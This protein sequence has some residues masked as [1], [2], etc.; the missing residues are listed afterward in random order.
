MPSSLRRRDEV[1]DSV[2]S[3]WIRF[4]MRGDGESFALV[5]DRTAPALL[6][7]ARRIARQRNDADD[8]IQA[9]FVTAI[10]RALDFDPTRA[11]LPWLIGILAGHAKNAARAARRAP[12]VYGLARSPNGPN[13]SNSSD[14]TQLASLI[15]LEERAAVALAIDELPRPYR[16]ILEAR[17]DASTS[18]PR[19]TGITPVHLRVGFHRA[20]RLLRRLLPQSLFGVIPRLIDARHDRHTIDGVRRIL[21]TRFEPGARIVA[22]TSVTMVGGI[23]MGKKIAAMAACVLLIVAGAWVLRGDRPDSLSEARDRRTSPA[24]TDQNASEPIATTAEAT[25]IE[26]N[27]IE[28]SPSAVASEPPV[29]FRGRIIDA[30]SG[31]PVAAATVFVDSTHRFPNSALPKDAVLTQPDGRFLI[32]RPRFDGH[33]TLYARS[34]DHAEARREFDVAEESAARRDGVD[35]GDLSIGSGATLH[36]RVLDAEGR[37]VEGARLFLHDE[38][39]MQWAF[40]PTISREVGVTESDG[41][42]VIEHVREGGLYR[43]RLFAESPRGCGGCDL[44]IPVG[45]AHVEGL[46]IRLFRAA[47]L[48]V[49][50]VDDSGAPL[51]GTFVSAGP[52]EPPFVWRS[53]TDRPTMLW[54]CET[55]SEFCKATDAAGRVRF[56]ALPLEMECALSAGREGHLRATASA[57]RL[58][59]TQ[60]TN[61][62]LVMPRLRE[63]A[64]SGRVVDSAGRG[65][66]GVRVERYD[67]YQSDLSPKVDEVTSAPDGAFRLEHVVGGDITQ[68][69]V[70]APGVARIPTSVDV[71]VDRDARDVVLVATP[72]APVEGI[73]VDDRGAPVSAASVAMRLPDRTLYADAIRTD[74]SG[75]FRISH[76]TAGEGRLIINLPGER[77]NWVQSQLESDVKCGSTNVRVIALRVDAGLAR[78]QLRIFDGASGEPLDLVSAW[79]YPIQDRSAPESKLVRIPGQVFGPPPRLEKGRITLERWRAG[80]WRAEVKCDARPTVVKDFEI[81][82]T[83]EERVFDVEVSRP[84]IVH[85]RVVGSG[86]D[87]Q[88]LAGALR[89][90]WIRGSDADGLGGETNDFEPTRFDL[91]GATE[92][93]FT[94]VPPR[95]VRFHLSSPELIGDGFVDATAG[96]ELEV[97]IHASRFGTVHLRAGTTKSDAG[98]SIHFISVHDAHLDSWG[99]IV[100]PDRVAEEHA[101][102]L[103][104]G[105][106]RYELLRGFLNSSAGGSD[107]LPIVATG[108]LTVVPGETFDLELPAAK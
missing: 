60:S 48:E 33:G 8:L 83:D 89:F 88:S 94:Q 16:E 40:Y 67:L 82:P 74:E 35:L 14:A 62:R 105:E 104:A 86:F 56:T 42:F 27:R 2:E 107:P 39:D 75:R 72:A 96:G 1:A 78:V 76:A 103:A 10:E 3:L 17:I 90:A 23:L 58:S 93:R 22:P 12:D 24:L 64:V 31:A 63:F 41:T 66:G 15:E 57:I 61:R 38:G 34:K 25:A 84:A 32:A 26:R 52:L 21:L 91:R 87:A 102:A 85:G 59:A 20:I 100:F 5:Y 65:I 51:E 71:P 55:E 37:S 106:W 13:S 98:L 49:E 70:G 53:E 68:L 36:G 54:S 50:L 44:N 9:T 79:V 101:F 45:K 69:C 18:V 97:E 43:F 80:R 19:K 95:P 81:A 92:F 4:A 28:P 11:L 108:S 7:V 47:T 46:E 77:W 73:V 30:T 6:A 29:L 99:S